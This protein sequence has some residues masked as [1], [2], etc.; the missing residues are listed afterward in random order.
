LPAITTVTPGAAILAFGASGRIT[1]TTNA[2][3]TSW[4]LT[5]PTLTEIFDVGHNNATNT[6]GVGGAWGIR[7]TT[8]S[9]GNGGFTCT[10]NTNPRLMGGIMLALRP[11]CFANAGTALGDICQGG[12][13]AALGGSVGGGATAGTWSASVPGPC[14]PPAP[15]GAPVPAPAR[16][17]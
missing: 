17:S 9:T 5:N 6:V 7:S 4:T 2:N 1:S 14:P 3:F 12:I 13:S 16:K 10:P 15:A 11:R 8:G